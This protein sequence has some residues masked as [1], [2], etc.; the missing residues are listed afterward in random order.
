L[1]S[2][3]GEAQFRKDREEDRKTIAALRTKNEQVLHEVKKK[4]AETARVR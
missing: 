3:K 4:D 2:R 1:K